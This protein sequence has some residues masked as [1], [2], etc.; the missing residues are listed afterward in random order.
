MS[1]IWIAK[2][3]GANTTAL[4][5]DLNEAGFAVLNQPVIDIAQLDIDALHSRPSKQ[6][7]LN[8]DRFQHLIFISTNAVKF[9]MDW[10]SSYWPQLPEKVTWYAIGAATQ[11][12]MKKYGVEAL[13]P[14]VPTSEGLLQLPQ[15]NQVAEH[16]I[17]LLKGIGGRT[18]IETTL[19]GRGADVA[20]IECYR[21]QAINE[22]DE[23]TLAVLNTKQLG[24]IVAL[25]IETLESLRA[26][27]I[28]YKLEITELIL[29]VPSE[30][31]A[32]AARQLGFVNIRRAI[33]AENSAIVAAIR[34]WK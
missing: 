22:L 15:L 34:S 6:M 32:K 8:L 7:V 5:N 11:T 26:L 23:E 13:Q 33:S 14:I 18:L 16:K 4:A 1:M 3:A 24:M 12:E 20:C 2:P 30:R 17:G 31:V 9:G 27:S 29:V 25:S 19:A 21:R 10:I 28:R